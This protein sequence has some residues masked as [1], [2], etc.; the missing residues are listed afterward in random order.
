MKKLLSLLV[1]VALLAGC[2][3]TT[4]TE[5]KTIR[6]GAT[7]V[8]H[9]EILEDVVKP[10]LEEEGWDVDI[11]VFTDYIQP[12][13][14]FTYLTTLFSSLLTGKKLLIPCVVLGQLNMT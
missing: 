13:T 5:D 6:I 1:A 4:D 8:P 7:Q 10:I 3:S 2:S 12:N 9:A 11:T 14:V